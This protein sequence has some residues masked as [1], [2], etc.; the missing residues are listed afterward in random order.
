MLWCLGMSVKMANMSG[1]KWYI[2]GAPRSRYFGQV[3]LFRQ[4]TGPYLSVERQ[5]ILTGGQ[6]GEGFGYDMT[7]ADFNGDGWVPQLLSGLTPLSVSII[8]CL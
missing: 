8:N 4:A 7:V 2:G 1:V 3:L 6:F 5:H